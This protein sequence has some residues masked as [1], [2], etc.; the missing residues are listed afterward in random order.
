MNEV[1]ELKAEL[2]ASRVEEKAAAVALRDAVDSLAAVVE[3]GSRAIRF[4]ESRHREKE[5]VSQV[6]RLMRA[7]RSL[8]ARHEK[9]QGAEA[10]YLEMR[11]KPAVSSIIGK[12]GPRVLLLETENASVYSRRLRPGEETAWLAEWEQRLNKDDHK[13]LEEVPS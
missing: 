1:Q 8:E 12:A 6:T 13:S 10:L 11:L 2:D 7:K 4:Q 3:E 5:T 9:G